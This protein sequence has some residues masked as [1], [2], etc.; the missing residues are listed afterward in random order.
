[1]SQFAI[2]YERQDVAFIVAELLGTNLTGNEQ[3]LANDAWNGGLRDWDIA[4]FA[5]DA[6]HDDPT[7]PACLLVTI[8]LGPSKGLQEFRDL[9]TFCGNDH[10]GAEY[11][12]ALSDDM[13]GGWSCAI[14]PWPPA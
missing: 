14:E 8:D 2:F 1:M 11:L 4:P 6:G 10:P 9:L 3:A 7:C 13:G 12:R 5:K